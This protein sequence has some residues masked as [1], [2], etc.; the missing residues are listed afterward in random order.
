M[1]PRFQW[2]NFGKN[3]GPG[4]WLNPFNLW[5]G[6]HRFRTDHSNEWRYENFRLTTVAP[7]P[8]GFI[9]GERSRSYQWLL[10]R[11]SDGP[12]KDGRLGFRCVILGDTGEGD[13]SQYALLPII[14][15]LKPD[16][17]IINGDVAYPAGAYD[18]F[19]QGFFAPY[20]G[21]N[22][23]IWAV[24]GNHEYYSSNRGR[25]FHTL[26]CSEDG[27][28]HWDANGLVFKPQP[29]TYWEL[30]EPAH[31]NAPVILGLD[32]GH[33]ADLE[34]KRGGGFLGLGS[35][36][37]PD[38][39]QHAWL[40]ERLQ[41]AQA[42]NAHVV[43]LYHIPALVNERHAGSTHLDWLHALIAQYSCIRVVITAHE[44]NYQRYN[45]GEFVLYLRKQFT[46]SP[47]SPGPTYL[48]SG[49]GGASLTSTTFN[50]GKK[51]GFKTSDR[52]PAADAWDEV[53]PFSSRVVNSVGL[54]KSIAAKVVTGGRRLF[55]AYDEDRPEG[56]SLLLLD[57]DGVGYGNLI[58]YFITDLETMYGH[59]L[60]GSTVYVKEGV[61]ACNDDAMNACRQPA[62]PL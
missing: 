8:P 44:H 48:V 61:P 51:T 47:V 58:P 62:I 9:T 2:P 23:P 19:A 52:F 32:S 35:S 18:D 27:R 15:Y 11:P 56:V 6:R 22:I 53:A 29:G 60:P 34:G 57:W 16:F 38:D 31:P 36:Q 13:K 4:Y 54:G 50:H 26:F 33:S 20:A 40:E 5:A 46:L 37:P 3:R 14:R 30:A 55:G 7:T 45:P 41:K 59:L 1:A 28:V 43:I 17:M 49:A 25:E 12:G 21:L 39:R 24:P 42:R 10:G